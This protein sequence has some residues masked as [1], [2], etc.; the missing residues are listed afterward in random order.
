MEDITHKPCENKDR[1]I[2]CG[3]Q[4]R[5]LQH[6]AQAYQQREQDNVQRRV[7]QLLRP[8]GPSLVIPS[9]L[10]AQLIQIQLT[11]NTTAAAL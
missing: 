9:L 8:K 1:K 2:R 7:C 5:P 11:C 6:E 3:R 10:R 4:S